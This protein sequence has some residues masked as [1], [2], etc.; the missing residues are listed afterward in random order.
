[1]RTNSSILIATN[2]DDHRCF[3]EVAR[4][5]SNKGHDVVVYKADEVADGTREFSAHVTST[6][7]VSF[8]YDNQS[9]SPSKVA[10]AWYRRP[11]NFGYEHDELRRF[12]LAEE[13]KTLQA[14]IWKSIR[15]QVWLNSPDSIRHADIKFSQLALAA[16][17]G[18][19]IPKTV[20][21]NSWQEIDSLSDEKLIV[22]SV[23]SGVLH[24]NIEAAKTMYTTVFQ[25]KNQLP[26]EVLPYPGIWQPYIPKSREWRITV[27][28]EQIFSVAIYTTDEAKDDW[29][30]HQFTPNFVINKVEK[31]P[32]LLQEKCV[33]MLQVLNLRF[34]AFDFIET[35]SGEVIF[36]E[37]NPNGQFTWLENELGLPISQAIS[38]ELA[39][40]AN[41]N[42]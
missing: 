41:N 24:S 38:E 35:P 17:L 9:F 20:V 29:R 31:F 25:N 28:G 22:K 39:V 21:S 30:K 36:L 42:S 15:P 7:D 12:S 34:G 37:L 26:K 4:R 10:A 14:N 6:G 2:S 18:L 3:S 33:E 13:Y 19:H 32:E 16:S 8:S 5:L 23:A 1:M 27:V 11:S 40:I